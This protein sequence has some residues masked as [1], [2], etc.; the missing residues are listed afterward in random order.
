MDKVKYQ[1]SYP[2]NIELKKKLRNGD[3]ALI[4]RASKVSRSLVI[5]I[6]EGTRKMNPRVKRVYD[7]I[8]KCN[9]ELE[10]YTG[11]K[12]TPESF[13]DDKVDPRLS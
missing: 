7:L 9:S 2:E 4:A 8:V 1:Y 12:L 3:L 11:V 13:I 6:F 10:K 5:K